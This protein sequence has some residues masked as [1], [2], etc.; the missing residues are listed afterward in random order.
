[1]L[2][3]AFSSGNIFTWLIKGQAQCALHNAEFLYNIC[4]FACRWENGIEALDF[5][6]P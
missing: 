1:M 4:V 3:F 2:H 6:T 5:Q